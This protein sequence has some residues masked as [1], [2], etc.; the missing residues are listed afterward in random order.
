MVSVLVIDLL[1][2]QGS[3]IPAG[4][5]EDPMAV[6]AGRE[7]RLLGGLPRP[8]EE[9]TAV[10]VFGGPGRDD[11]AERAVRAAL[12][13]VET[14]AERGSMR[15]TGR[16]P[17]TGEGPS[18]RVRAAV[19]TG[20]DVAPAGD[21][22]PIAPDAA[23]VAAGE[24]LTEGFGG[25][26]GV[27][28][29]V[30]DGPTY[31]ATR[32][33]FEYEPL[34]SPKRTWVAVK[35]RASYGIDV[36]LGL[37]TPFTGRD[38]ELAL[39]TDIYARVVMEGS[40]HVVTVIGEA[41]TGKSR[42]LSEFWSA[43]DARPELVYWRQGR[44]LAGSLAPGGGITLWAL[45]EVVKGQA[46]ILESD[47]LHPAREKLDV[48]LRSLLPDEAERAAVGPRLR[49]LVGLVESDPTPVPRDRSFPA[50][51]RF[52]EAMA[53]THT[54][55]LVFEDLHLAD[56]G[57]LAFLH[58][59][60]DEASGVP[61]LMICT[62]RF[63]LLEHDRTW[64]GATAGAAHSTTIT[65]G[66][67]PGRDA[68]NLIA[69]MGGPLEAG[70][71]PPLELLESAEGNPLYL[72]MYVGLLADRAVAGPG[73]EPPP[74]PPPTL[75]ALMEAR[76]DAL[77]PPLR[78][79]IED[80]AVVGK[81]FWPGAV[82]S[83]GGRTEDEVERGFVELVR[84]GLIRHSRRSSV[85]GQAEYAFWHLA[86]RDAA[87]EHMDPARSAA[88]HRAALAWG[89]SMSGDREADH[90]EILASHV[91]AALDTDRAGNLDAARRYLRLAADRAAG[92]D[93][94][95]A[96]ELYRRAAE[97]F[98]PASSERDELQARASAASD[99]AETEA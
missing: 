63:E 28:G 21:D 42:L 23:V 29:V 80:A 16:S 43:L 17:E 15:S 86:L 55:V 84:R 11:S 8:S 1:G 71:T 40:P 60:A 34:E 25:V 67:L 82:S 35:S 12:R 24:M 91:V 44:S 33:L 22:L 39:L 46:G 2:P 47:D 53:S 36:E 37:P 62:G 99:A 30:V 81:V 87:A 78:E 69:A 56:P 77:D 96:A 93:P 72:E 79:L 27:G 6:R 74:S 32:D 90:S 89:S 75:A 51:L 73:P 41:G 54:M 68:R 98:P 7:I 58:H 38:H 76:L 9:H 45:G 50:W 10:G 59:I 95:R 57:T 26:D 94:A 48:A 20:R 18:A 85:A 14:A 19:H 31:D 64:G 70:G 88:A 49:P 83:V 65:L 3:P 61:L 66:P 92:L 13:F 4:T 97:L 5:G 52:L